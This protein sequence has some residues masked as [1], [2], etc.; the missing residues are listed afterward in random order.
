MK[1]LTKHFLFLTAPLLA[2]STAQAASITV[3][4]TA[5]TL[6]NAITAAN[7]DTAIGSCAAG[8]GEDTIT[9]QQDALLT[10]PLPAISST[11]TIDG[12]GHK[13]DGQND[14][15]VGSVL[16]VASSGVLTLNNATVTGGKSGHDG[17]GLYNDGGTV[18]LNSTTVSGNATGDD[19]GS[20]GGIYNSGTLTLNDSSISSN[21]AYYD[22]GGI[23]NYNGTVTLNNST[24]SDNT[25][26]QYG[27]GIENSSGT[28][29]L[30][31]TTLSGNQATYGG[32]GGLDNYGGTATLTNTTISNNETE[33]YYGSGI[34]MVGGTLTLRSCL[35]S[36]NTAGKEVYLESGTL[37]ANSYNVFGHSGETTAEALY[38]FT[39]GAKDR[40]ATSDGTTPT[41]LDALLTTP[42]ADNGGPTKTH[43]LPA[44]SPAIDLDTTCSTGTDQRGANRPSGAGCDAGAFEFDS[45]TTTIDDDGIDDGGKMGAI[46][47]LLLN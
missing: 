30:N 1:L 15:N 17:G 29:T 19:D 31:N 2:V 26:R 42:L 4:G 22:G 16:R 32:G 46:Y 44:G 35:V 25:A 11:V 6:A 38:G 24:V 10:A 9:L 7:T 8:S 13:I 34:D 40:T 41:A 5:C 33:E 47:N 27:G 45:A 12:T 14:A 28:L 23:D 39:P 21:W 3:D 37:I 18:T 20:G 36:G 43:A